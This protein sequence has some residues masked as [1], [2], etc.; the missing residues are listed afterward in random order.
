MIH[1]S[2]HTFH[3]PVMGL[4]FTI[5]TPL[6]VAKY[7]ISSV[8]SIMDDHLIEEMR[9]I[10]SKNFNKPFSPISS[11][12]I[13]RRYKRIMSYLNL[14]NEVVEE[15]IAEIRKSDFSENSELTKYFS[16][17]PDEV[18]A[19]RLYR[20]MLDTKDS[21]IKKG[22]QKELKTIVMAGA[23]DVN[24]MSKLDNVN[25]DS[26]G[27][28]LPEIYS[29]AKSALK[30]F[31]LSSLSSSII[32]SAGMNPTL[33]S[34]CEEFDDFYPNENGDIKKKVILKV[35]DFRAA[36]IQ[37]KLF[38]KKG[39][40]VSEFRIE[41]GLNCGGHAFATNGFLL[42]PILEEF[43]EKRN[44]LFIELYELCKEA[45]L[46]NDRNPFQKL[47]SMSVKVQGGIGTSEEN[48]FL[49]SQY[50]L[51]GTGW[52]SPFLLVPEST[53]V[54]EFTL[55]AL[56]KSKKEDFYLSNSS[57]LGVPF[58]NFKN[59]TS[60][61]QR[62]ER[63]AKN[64]AGSPCY[65]KFLSFN[66]EFTKRPICTASR[67]YQVL[68]IKEIEKSDLTV[69][70]KQKQIYKTLEKECLCEGL[71]TSAIHTNKGQIS[72]KLTAVSICPG[73][74]LYFFKETYKLNEMV[75]HIYGRSN[76][77]AQINRPHIFYNEAVLYVDY[78]KKEIEEKSENMSEKTRIYL[79]G[80]KENLQK[81]L[82]YYSNLIA[83][84]KENSTTRFELFAS[85]IDELRMKLNK[86]EISACNVIK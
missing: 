63:I 14:M 43:K 20:R 32:F 34:Y 57:P 21:R 10:H 74:N 23:I 84:V 64:R 82:N 67:H 29:D 36:L 68:K 9:R 15:Q 59:C 79:Q 66:T 22:I 18:T 37:G 19:K 55:S 12:D 33:F 85:Q 86:L 30:G 73:P 75:D 81:G 1:T 80:F 26:K 50:A 7:G 46:K 38:A 83:S 76:V 11:Q 51:D 3:I 56:I 70:K 2:L 62:L 42:G 54:D 28:D 27:N 8:V 72:H 17:L 69:E 53:N 6:K 58:N 41:S 44:A 71:G 35:S 52:G 61:I 24:I 45:L 60:E 5:D 13:D 48:E 4:G 77:L 40:W 78:L 31:A 47:P 39:I 49:I 25:V 16:L 65:K